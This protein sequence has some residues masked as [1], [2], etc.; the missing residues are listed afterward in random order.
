M[1]LA[2]AA[3]TAAITMDVPEEVLQQ[4]S[5]IQ[6]SWWPHSSSD[7]FGCLETLCSG[8]LTSPHVAHAVCT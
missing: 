1:L 4:L 6:V 5:D 8:M 7:L 2:S 3:A